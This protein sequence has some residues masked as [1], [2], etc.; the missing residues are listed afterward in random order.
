MVVAG[1]A[2]SGK[3]IW[4]LGLA[5][6]SGLLLISAPARA[7][8]MTF[9]EQYRYDAG[10]ADSKLSCRAISLLLVKQLLLERLGTYIEST[11]QVVDMQLSRDEV[12]SLSAGIVKTEI[13]DESWDGKTYTLTAR[14]QA[15]PEEV[16][17]LLDEIGGTANKQE[18]IARLDQVN[19]DGL[20]K[21]IQLKNQ[22]EAIQGD[23]VA[24]NRDY[25]QAARVVEAW[26]AVERGHEQM[27]NG[28]F[29][30]AVES[31]SRALAVKPSS[32]NYL[33]RALAFRQLKKLT[34]ALADLDR[35]I[36]MNPKIGEAYFQRGQILRDIGRK[37][38]GMAEIRRAAS[39]GN[40][41]AGLWLKA[42]GKR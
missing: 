7:E 28:E 10:E 19:Q 27:R 35:V 31:F 11:T 25:Q 22:M 18:E 12:T 5:V 32:D 3:T 39:M 16:I 15:D 17:R 42:K 37:Q 23:L 36:Q 40:G 30:A 41:K 26:G 2:I 13:L 20:E 29:A 34:L 33:Q 6:V 8:L 24:V 21:I 38:E 1:W 14:I 9:E 4:R